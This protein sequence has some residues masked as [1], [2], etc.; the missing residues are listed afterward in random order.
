MGR[1]RFITTGLTT[2][3][4]GCGFYLR[5]TGGAGKPIVLHMRRGSERRQE[6]CATPE[7]A[8]ARVIELCELSP[9]DPR[10]PALRFAL[11]LAPNLGRD[12]RRPV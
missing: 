3:I 2:G 6:T 8:I 5:V 12:A 10:I 1:G 9:D 7:A 11:T 4:T